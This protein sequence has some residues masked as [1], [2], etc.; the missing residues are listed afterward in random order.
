V[1]LLQAWTLG[2]FELVISDHLIIEIVRTLSKP[3]FLAHVEPGIFDT[4]L[5]ALQHDATRVALTADVQ[6][7]ATHH[8]DDFVLATAVSAVA[9]YLVTGDK[10]LQRLGTYENV[11]IISPRAF[12]TLLSSQ[13]DADPA[14]KQSSP[15]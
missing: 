13:V 1:L 7:V 10:Q 15:D 9:D 12:L 6:R 11:T 14:W 8:E 2:V 4:T 3:Y 5:A